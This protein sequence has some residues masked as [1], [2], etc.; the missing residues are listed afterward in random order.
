[1]RLQPI[2]YAS[3]MDR[4]VGWY[5]A[6]LGRAPVSRSAAWSAFDIGGAMLGIHLGER[7]A[8]AG[9]V[10]LSL[11]ATAPL[12][13]VL[14]RLAAAGITP[15]GEIVDQPFGRSFVLRD[16]EGLAVQVNEHRA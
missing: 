11:I 3:S 16:P 8:P 15:E 6:V 5:E 14:A 13:E 9:P 4:T 1:M 2:V 10:A 7:T 12:E